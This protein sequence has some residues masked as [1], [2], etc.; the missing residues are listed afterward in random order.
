[1][2][3]SRDKR[4]VCVLALFVVLVAGWKLVWLPIHHNLHNYREVYIQ[5][6]ADFAWMHANASRVSMPAPSQLQGDNVINAFSSITSSA[7]VFNIVL[8]HAEPSSE[9][10]VRVS[11][12]SATFTDIITWLEMLQREHR[13]KATQASIVRTTPASALVAAKF[14]LQQF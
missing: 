8:S 5:N 12:S 3:S 13:I 9:G 2:L 11:I 6:A 1:M 10:L 14:T 7:G 4:A